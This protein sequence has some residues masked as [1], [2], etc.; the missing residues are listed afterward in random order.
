MKKRLLILLLSFSPVLFAQDGRP[1][2]AILPFESV[3]LNANEKQTIEKLVQSYISEL[4]EFRLVTQSD[5]EK[6]LS[7]QEFAAV[8]NDPGQSRPSD[9]GTLG[10]A[11]FL[12]S[13]SIG[14]LGDERILTLEAV[15][16]KTGEKKSVSSIHRSMSDLALGVRAL[17]LLVFE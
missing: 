15:T 2:V 5:R 6:A 17:V 3:D 1:V 14:T 16:I 4:G 7:E 9:P 10:T 11:Q 12:L 8:V 13:G